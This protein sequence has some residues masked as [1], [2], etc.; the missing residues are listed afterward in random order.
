ME[1]GKME[2]GKMELGKM[3]L[4]KMELAKDGS[5]KD[6]FGGRSRWEVWGR[7][8]SML[9][10][11]LDAGGRTRRVLTTLID[12]R[13]RMRSMLYYVLDAVGACGEGLLFFLMVLDGVGG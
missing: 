11:V 3:E 13:G 6:G 12:A 4:G 10:Y 7:M 5:G 8:R 2:L 9:Y 1:L